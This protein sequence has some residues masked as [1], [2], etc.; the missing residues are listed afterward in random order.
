[1]QFLAA[2]PRFLRL[3]FLLFLVFGAACTSL[4]FRPLLARLFFGCRRRRTLG[5]LTRLILGLLLGLDFAFALLLLALGCLFLFGLCPFLL[6]LFG[7]DALQLF[8]ALRI[9]RFLLFC[10]LLFEHISLDIGAL[11]PHLDI[12]GPRSTLRPG[13]TQFGL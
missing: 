4:G 1:M 9:E 8:A 5:F 12:H 3:A 13:K 7:L 10:R 2:V 6:A 11:F